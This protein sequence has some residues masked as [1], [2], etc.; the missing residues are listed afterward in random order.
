MPACSQCACARVVAC[1]AFSGDTWSLSHFMPAQKKLSDGA[2]PR[3]PSHLVFCEIPVKNKIS[4]CLGLLWLG[5]SVTEGG[6]LWL[7]HACP[8]A[9]I[10]NK[11]PLQELRC[12]KR[13]KL[14]ELQ[15]FPPSEIVS[16]LS[17]LNVKSAHQHQLNTQSKNP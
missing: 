2:Q 10:S 9:R 17:H 11:T 4:L 16:V 3:G 14:N 8:I 15:I 7:V 6:G 13:M 12:C 1:A 5:S